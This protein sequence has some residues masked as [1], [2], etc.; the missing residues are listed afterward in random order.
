MSATEDFARLKDC[1]FNRPGI[2]HIRQRHLQTS[3]MTGRLPQPFKIV[4]Y[5][6]A[7]KVIENVDMRLTLGKQVMRQV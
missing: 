6:G 1:A 7:G 4:V 5:T 2:P 3:G